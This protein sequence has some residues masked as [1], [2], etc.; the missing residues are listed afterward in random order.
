MITPKKY[1]ASKQF[2]RGNESSLSE[3][4]D[5]GKWSYRD[6]KFSLN[7]EDG[8]VV[9]S[10]HLVAFGKCKIL[11]KE[12]I[13]NMIATNINSSNIK[14]MKSNNNTSRMKHIKKGGNVIHTHT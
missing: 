2:W 8:D 13:T 4:G 11:M 1:K 7:L 12:S 6:I 10:L 3:I 9:R 5:L 14:I